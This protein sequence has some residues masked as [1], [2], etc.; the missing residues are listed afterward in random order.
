M[1]N[2]EFKIN[3]WDLLL[4]AGKQDQIEF[5]NK[6]I[7]ELKNLDKSGISGDVL[8]QS[9]DQN[10]LL[11]T[12]E[13]LKCIIKETCDKCTSN[14]DRK[15]KIQE[16]SAKFQNKIDKEETSDDEIFLIDWNE[17]IDLKDMIMQAITLQQPFTNICPKCQKNI[18]IEDEE[19]IDY[20]ESTG[21]ITFS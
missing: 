21:N 18:T 5:K 4:S 14:F 20:F 15:V 12:I 13:N 11:V 3:V 2:S 19:D 17:N 7:E 6:F 16:Y 10:S 9:F 8:I 1:K